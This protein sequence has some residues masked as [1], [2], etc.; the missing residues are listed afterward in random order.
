MKR[1]LLTA[2]L[3]SSCIAP[4]SVFSQENGSIEANSGSSKE[5][6]LSKTTASKKTALIATFV[7]V[8]AT[9]IVT[10]YLCEKIHVYRAEKIVKG[11]GEIINKMET[12]ATSSLDADK[13]V[14]VTARNYPLNLLDT[15]ESMVVK[16]ASLPKDL[17][18]AKGIL[19]S[20]NPSSDY[21]NSIDTYLQRLA[22]FGP[23]LREKLVLFNEL[24][25]VIAAINKAAIDNFGY[26]MQRAGVL[27]WLM[28]K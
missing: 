28:K 18:W 4:V 16:E 27:F 9:V 11:A 3:I 19:S 14:A 22:K 23:V 25:V 8:V 2:F 10:Y 26:L 6:S 1:L 17:I 7:G 13:L 15:Y 21:L 24:P 5:S 12:F 20:K